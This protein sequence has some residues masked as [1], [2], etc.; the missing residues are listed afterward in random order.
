[1][2]NPLPIKALQDR[3]IAAAAKAG[4]EFFMDLPD[5]W[6]EP[7]PTYGC[8]NG[9]VSRCY[10]KSEEHGPLCLECHEGIAMLPHHYDTDEKLQAA[11]D[12]IGADQPADQEKGK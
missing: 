8:N 6:Y 5:A 2:S 11:L 1:M 7:R 3:E 4:E 10:L 9:H 12:E